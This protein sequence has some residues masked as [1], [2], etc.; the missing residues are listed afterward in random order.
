MTEA[1]IEKAIQATHPKATRLTPAD[2]DRVIVGEDFHVFPGTTVTVCLLTLKNGAK[3]IGHN[4]GSIDTSQQDWKMGKTEAR[5]MA[6]NTV[7]ELEG[8]RLRQ[9]LSLGYRS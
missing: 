8:Y 6:I 1:A 5:K 4:Y 7:W 2:I 3:A 9:E